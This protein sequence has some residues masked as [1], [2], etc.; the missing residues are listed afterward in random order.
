MLFSKNWWTERNL[1]YGVSSAGTTKPLQGCKAYMQINA[2]MVPKGRGVPLPWD[3]TIG[4]SA[5][6]RPLHCMTS[7][8]SQKAACPAHIAGIWRE[9]AA[10]AMSLELS[11]EHLTLLIYD[12]PLPYS[13]ALPVA[14]A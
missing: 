9:G 3:V 6:I 11:T 7:A 2:Y 4:A 14:V 12:T 1:N 10:S 13:F 5:T 8:V